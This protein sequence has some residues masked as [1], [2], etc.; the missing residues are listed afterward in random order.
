RYKDIIAVIDKKMQGRLDSPLHLAA[1]LL[2][3]YYSYANQFIFDDATVTVGFIN[4][5]ETFYHHDESMQEQ[6]VNVELRKFQSREGHFSKKLAK[7][8]ENFEYNPASWWRLYGTQTPS[9][10][11]LAVRILFLT[12]SSSAC[13]R[14]WSTFELVLF[15]AHLSSTK[16]QQ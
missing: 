10:Q 3:P 12:S 13:E 9:L 15:L 4:C 8:C 6:A 2:N 14:N 1:Y 16:N 5:V 7:T 11:R